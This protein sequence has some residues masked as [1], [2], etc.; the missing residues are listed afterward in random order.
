MLADKITGMMMELDDEILIDYCKNTDKMIIVI[1]H[2]SSMLKEKGYSP[3]SD[4]FK[5][6]DK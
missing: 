3:R 4:S 5:L 1:A 2:T 6:I